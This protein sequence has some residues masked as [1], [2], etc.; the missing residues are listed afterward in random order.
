MFMSEVSSEG[1]ENIDIH[2][3]LSLTSLHS[4]NVLEASE[5]SSAL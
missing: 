5:E 2:G 1:V 3:W 4:P